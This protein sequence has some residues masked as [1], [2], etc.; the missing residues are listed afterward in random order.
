MELGSRPPGIEQRP[1]GY[2]GRHRRGKPALEAARG[3][4]PGER[5]EEQPEV[6]SP[7]MDQEPFQNGSR[8]F[9][10]E[11]ADTSS[12]CTKSPVLVE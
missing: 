5:P 8:S 9:E 4:D 11:G 10:G 2:Q 3:A 1:Q 6:E 7:D 12:R